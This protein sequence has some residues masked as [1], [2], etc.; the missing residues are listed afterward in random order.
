MDQSILETIVLWVISVIDT[1]G[2]PGIF[3]LMAIESALIPIPS[4]VIMP[5]SGF[6]VSQGKFNLLAVILVGALGNLAG[7]WIAYALGYWGEKRLIRK[8]VI[9]YGK[10]ILLTEEEFDSSIKLFNKYG[11]WA[12]AVSRILPAIRTV[13]SLPAGMAK[14]PFWKF[15][16][17]TFFGSLI[18]S[19]FLTLIGVKLGENWESIRP[20][21]RKFDVL[22]IILAIIAVAAYV[23]HKLH[24]RKL[25]A[26]KT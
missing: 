16:A 12:A 19:A 4:E 23:Y 1:L 7:S 26:Q 2:Y 15:S 25:S 6:L 13:I 5:F 21:F 11:Q 22:I 9:K 3:V 17:L 14:L 20:L 10:F 18:W 24:K 8:L